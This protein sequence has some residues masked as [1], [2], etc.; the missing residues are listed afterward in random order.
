MIFDNLPAVPVLDENRVQAQES[1]QS[2]VA[3]PSFKA[4]LLRRQVPTLSAWRNQTRPLLQTYY[5]DG[6]KR[7]A[8]NPK[9]N[10]SREPN[11]SP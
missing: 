9:R 5:E 11:S 3:K 2:E 10:S 1:T 6:W 4:G 7:D 8:R